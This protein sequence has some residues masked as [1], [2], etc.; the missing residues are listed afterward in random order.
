MLQA[1]RFEC[2]P[3]DPF[4]FSQ[5][6]FITPELDVRRRQIVEALVILPMIIVGHELFD[7]CLK[8]ARQK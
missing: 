3:F 4:S 7:T 2:L 8:I 6:D 1:P 5:D